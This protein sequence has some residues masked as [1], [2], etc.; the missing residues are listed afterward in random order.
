MADEEYEERLRRIRDLGL[1]VEEGRVR[2]TGEGRSIYFYD[3]DNHLFE[4][5]SGSLAERLARYAK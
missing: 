3:D 1:E 5:H 4:L 2:V